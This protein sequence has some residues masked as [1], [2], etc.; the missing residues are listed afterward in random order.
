MQHGTRIASDFVH[1]CCII[2]LQSI[3]YMTPDKLELIEEDA[4]K[5]GRDEK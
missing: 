5:L 1:F 3:V 4:G 2:E